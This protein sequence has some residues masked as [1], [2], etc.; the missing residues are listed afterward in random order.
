MQWNAQRH[1][2]QARCLMRMLSV[3]S[4]AIRVVHDVDGMIG[5]RDWL[6]IRRKQRDARAGT[7]PLRRDTRRSG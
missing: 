6:Q 4:T 5:V 7:G 1:E 3:V 2:R